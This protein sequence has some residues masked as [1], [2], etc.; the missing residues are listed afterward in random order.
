MGDRRGGRTVLGEECEKAGSHAAK[1]EAQMDTGVGDVTRRDGGGFASPVLRGVL[2]AAL[3]G[4]AAFLLLRL[5]SLGGLLVLSG[6]IAYLLLPLQKRLESRLPRAW[7][8]AST[9][10]LPMGVIGISLYLGLPILREEAGRLA[11]TLPSLLDRISR[12]IADWAGRLGITTDLTEVQSL[13]TLR[14]ED[15]RSWILSITRDGNGSTWTLLL[16]SVLAFYLLRDRKGLLEGVQFAVPA[17]YRSRLRRL[18][19]RVHDSLRMFIRGQLISAS[20]VALLTM[21]GLWLVGAPFW[22]LGA[23]LMGALDLIP[24]FGPILGTVLIGVI[25]LA[26]QPAG[27]LKSVLVAF[28]VQQI[29][30]GF[31]VP[32]V[33]GDSLQ[34]HPVT[35][36]LVILAGGLLLGTGGMILAIPVYITLRECLRAAPDFLQPREEAPGGPALPTIGN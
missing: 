33:L 31:I 24:T 2:A 23:F 16:S 28:A 25:T 18:L 9:I 26:A 34:L 17:H 15:V 32:C 14:V 4:A 12:F 13:L 22:F 8:A 19:L 36:M 1:N 29:E 21:A 35:V 11:E 30:G 6:I 7:A 27:V 5:R 3:L 10:L 20:F